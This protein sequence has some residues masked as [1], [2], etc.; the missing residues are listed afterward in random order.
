MVETDFYNAINEYSANYLHGEIR[1]E[2]Q[3]IVDD[4]DVENVFHLLS[5]M[6][7]Y[8]TSQPELI[9]KSKELEMKIDVKKIVTVVVQYR[10]HRER[11]K[12]DG[13]NK[14]S[15]FF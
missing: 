4:S 14:R 5:E 10:R 3:G 2:L 13:T 6:K 7:K 15:L 8:R 1:N 9:N 12:G 11:K